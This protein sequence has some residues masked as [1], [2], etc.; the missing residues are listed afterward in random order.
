M[1]SLIKTFQGKTVVVTGHTGFKGSWLSLWLSHLG[2]NVIGISNTIPT[3]PSNFIASELSNKIIDK[4]IDITDFKKLNLLIDEY[5]PDFIFHLAAQ[6]LVKTSYDTPLSTIKTNTIGSINVLEILRNYKKQIVVIMITSDKV[7]HNLE[8]EHAYSENDILGGK[9]PYSASKSMIEIA[10]NAYL[11]S[12]FNNNFNKVRIG[13]ARAGNVIGGGDWA[14]NRIVPDCMKA[15]SNNKTVDI[16]YPKSTRPWQHVLEPL[17][18]YLAFADNLSRSNENHGESFNFGPSNDQNHTVTELIQEMS[19][20]WSSVKWRDISKSYNHLHEASLLQLNC[21]KANKFLNWRP[22]LLFEETV[23]LTVD[24]Y[25]NYY[26]NQTNSMFELSLKQI[27]E[28]SS[29]ALN[30]SINWAQQ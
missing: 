23:S 3:D 28:Y 2:A 22:T 10:I 13:I 6:S 18:G 8:I 17:S 30:R 26:S 19:K 16:R 29:L 7:Y 25:K 21:E 24:W 20:S 1:N 11:S 5:Q 4:R 14:I 9:D 12:Y 15:W 27:K